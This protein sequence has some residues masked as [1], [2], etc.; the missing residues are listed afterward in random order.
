[1]TKKKEKETKVTFNLEEALNELELPNML[2]VGFKCY[3]QNNNLKF[4]NNKD[5]EKALQEFKE[6]KL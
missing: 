4:K 3:I 5:F 1:M 2:I 6:L